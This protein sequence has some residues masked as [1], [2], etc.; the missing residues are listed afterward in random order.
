MEKS[1]ENKSATTVQLQAGKKLRDSNMELLRIVC[2]IFILMMHFDFFF[3]GR[4]SNEMISAQPASSFV[5][6]L[7][8]AISI[9]SVNVFV[10]ISG[11]YGIRAK[12]SRLWG[13]IFQ[14]F[15]FVLITYMIARHFNAFDPDGPNTLFTME[16]LYLYWFVTAYILLYI[17]TPA[18]NVFVENAP[19]RQ[20]QFVLVGFYVFQTLCGKLF[21]GGYSP[22]SFMGLYLLARY[23]KLYK[24]A[25]TQWPRWCDMLVYVGMT[26]LISVA[27]MSLQ[28]HHLRVMDLYAY[29]CPLVIVS[30]VYFFLFFTKFSFHNRFVNWVATSC[31]AVYLL[32]CGYATQ[33][34]KQIVQQWDSTLG[35]SSFVLHA[36]ALGA[37]IFVLAICIDKMRLWLWNV[38]SGQF[39]RAR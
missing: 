31:L 30:S 12:T 20:L 28:M 29:S 26:L 10:L 32:H 2:M 6:F 19:K 15:F 16:V 18:L 9:I 13:L 21:Y 24:P 17:F 34:F 35:T 14:Y 4:P 1:S 25:W 38:L 27:A 5:R 7:V 39:S 23:M 3:L 22:L 11:W 33:F 8:E 37:G 36:V